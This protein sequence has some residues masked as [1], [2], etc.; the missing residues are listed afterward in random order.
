MKKLIYIL[1]DLF[2]C[3]GSSFTKIVSLAIGLAVGILAFSYCAFETDYDN[4]HAHADRIY[5]I[6][7][8]EGETDF[9]LTLIEEAARQIPEIEEVSSIGKN[10]YPNYRYGDKVF[11]GGDALRADTS[12]FRLFSYRL[13]SGDPRDLQ[14]PDKFFISD[15]AARIIFG[16]ENPLG[17]EVKFG[18]RSITVAGVFESFPRNSHLMNI[19]A[20]HPLAEIA[21]EPGSGLWAYS[22]YIR[23]S[24]GTD[25]EA[26]AR[27][28]QR[29][30]A[31][32]LSK[33]VHPYTLTLQP[34]RD[35]HLK[36]GWGYSYLFLVGVMG[37]IIVLISALNYILISLSSLL[38]KTKEIGIHKI[39]GAS[40][41]NIFTRFFTE[42]L[43]LT[44][45]A[46]LLALG[47]LIAFKPFF[48]NIM[49][50]E[51]ASLFNTRV[52]IVLAFFLLFM[53]ILTGLLPARLFAS[54]PVLQ[55]FRKVS[56]GRRSW[57]YGLLWVQFFSACLLLTLLLIFDGQY[58]MMMNKNLGYEMKNLYYIELAC[59]SPYPSLA[60]VKEEVKR[61]PFVSDVSFT[62]SIPLW[63]PWGT[64]YDLNGQ[65]LFESCVIY[66]DEDFFSTL[67]I[68]LLEGDS[69]SFTGGANKA[70]VN[71]K[72]R[73]K[74]GITGTPETGV[75]LGKRSL[76]LCGTCRNFH[77][78][79]LYVNQQPVTVLGLQEPDTNR[80]YYLLIRM[81]NAKRTQMR[82]LLDQVCQVSNQPNLRL[83]YYPYTYQAG[84]QSDKDMC[85]TVGLF[86][87]LA[88]VVAILGLFG[89]TGDEISRR[90]KEIAVRKVNGASVLSITLLL[91]RNISLLALLA[92]PFALTGAYF[93]G[94]FW[95]EE[96]A[97]QLPLGVGIF[98][99][100][101]ATTFAIILFT[102][103]LKSRKGIHARPAE[104]LKSE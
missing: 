47:A 66:S 68:P 23:L 11:Q 85:T 35:L 32:Y 20:L 7:G 96:F 13:L 2:R 92:I 38:Q 97:F 58:R 62:S 74:L 79:S 15:K 45:M 99:G 24:P 51:Y 72:F 70:W 21:G 40:S 8:T 78:L 9:P 103:L 90:T 42:T 50:N 52:L 30:A 55:I 95:L 69:V 75:K 71:E 65:G 22:G 83:A 102:V 31:P 6:G 84:Y 60:S 61:F 28:I 80:N 63:A 39:N 26:V 98:L 57:K 82:E 18:D 12:F 94:S 48:E 81:E 3:K 86:S 41:A 64:V 43:L 101:A 37:F 73:D 56:Q 54:I 44:F 77:V 76:S 100:G 1:R 49:Y 14:Y 91:L 46:G 36:Y 19:Y 25:P 88:I 93:I 67:K 29:I 10:I 16:E 53:I 5:R 89:F 104:T 33:V 59:G 27:K 87:C 4:F 17:K 34:L